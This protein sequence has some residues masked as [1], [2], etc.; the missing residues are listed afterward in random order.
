MWEMGVAGSAVIGRQRGRSQHYCGGL[1]M[2]V[3]AL[4]LVKYSVPWVTLTLI[5]DYSRLRLLP[6]DTD[7]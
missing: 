4:C 1:D 3:L 6:G 2:L 5:A 7:V